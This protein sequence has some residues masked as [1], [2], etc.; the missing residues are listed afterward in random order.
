MLTETQLR[1][2]FNDWRGRSAESED[3]AI[4]T[5]VLI[6]NYMN[7]KEL[8]TIETELTPGSEI[9][10]T[11]MTYNEKKELAH[12]YGSIVHTKLAIDAYYQK[13]ADNNNLPNNEQ[14]VL[15]ALLKNLT[16]LYN[17]PYWY[18]TTTI[19]QLILNAQSWLSIVDASNKREDVI[20]ACLSLFALEKILLCTLALS[21]EADRAGLLRF[22]IDIKK[23]TTEINALLE[24]TKQTMLS[25]ETTAA[26]EE[27]PAYLD[28]LEYDSEM[29]SSNSDDLE[30]ALE[31]NSDVLNPEDNESETDSNDDEFQ[32]ALEVNPDVQDPNASENVPLPLTIDMHFDNPLISLLNQGDTPLIEKMGLIQ[33]KLD[34]IHQKISELKTAKERKIALNLELDK[35]FLAYQKPELLIDK[36]AFFVRPLSNTLSPK[37]EAQA[38][39]IQLGGEYNEQG[40]LSSEGT[41]QISE[42]HINTLI[43]NMADTRDEVKHELQRL[44]IPELEQ[45]MAKNRAI[46][47]VIAQ[48]TTLIDQ[49]TIHHQNLV[50]IQGLDTN[51]DAFI[52]K[53]NTIFVKLSHFIAQW[54]G[55]WF[56]T[57]AADKIEKA[58]VMKQAL[59]AMRSHYQN[60]F[61]EGV[62]SIHNNTNISDELKTTFEASLQ[63]SLHTS[64]LAPEVPSPSMVTRFNLIETLFNRLRPVL[65]E[66]NIIFEEDEAPPQP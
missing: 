41:L 15:H 62:T 24:K 45:L 27:S 17:Y 48:F 6:A 56:K 12:I 2:N 13:S 42:N 64:E 8:S 30:D 22:G 9:L 11:F 7:G 52:L 55:A 57:D 54:L 3:Y 26:I 35:A 47:E 63:T 19:N 16:S 33:E 31:E 61:D 34:T 36:A 37:A 51:I 23:T 44:Q 38:K 18:P 65:S 40:M 1:A 25:L 43:L 49:M 58:R 10:T 14:T 59:P 29:D 28:A 39:M 21:N 20:F 66:Q 5:A 50:Q 60:Q 53:H 32:D 4:D 46:H